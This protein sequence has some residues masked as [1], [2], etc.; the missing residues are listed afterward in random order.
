MFEIYKNKELTYYKQIYV[1][2]VS[3]LKM[4]LGTIN[5]YEINVFKCLHNL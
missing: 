5:G 2:L 4:F 1:Y 3:L